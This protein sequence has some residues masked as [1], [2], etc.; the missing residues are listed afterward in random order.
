M[1]SRAALVLCSHSA[2][3]I[4]GLLVL[5]LSEHLG[6]SNFF[7]NWFCFTRLGLCTRSFL[8]YCLCQAE[9]K[10]CR[11]T[12]GSFPDT[13]IETKMNCLTLSKVSMRWRARGWRGKAI[14]NNNNKKRLPN[15]ET[16]ISTWKF[17]MVFPGEAQVERSREGKG[18]RQNQW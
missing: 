4:L 13:N 3:F 17:V 10:C 6:C 1:L 12:R 8:V 14:N 5:I 15:T 9:L 7:L 2:V 18:R 16:E 11:A